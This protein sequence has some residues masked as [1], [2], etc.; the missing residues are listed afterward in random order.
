[1][2][3]PIAD[4]EVLTSL[5]T[6]IINTV[7]ASPTRLLQEHWFTKVRYVIE[8]PMNDPI[9]AVLLTR[10][11]FDRLS[12]DVQ[13][14]MKQTLAKHLK[15]FNGNVLEEN[16]EAMSVLYTD[17]GIQRIVFDEDGRRQFEF[18]GEEVRVQNL[19]RLWDEEILSA[20]MSALQ[21]YRLEQQN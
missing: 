5:Q 8:L 16:Q 9:G 3:V 12:P 19:G 13:I 11:S 20:A 14:L 21:A 6:G 1:M 17:H 18:L 2:P 7:Y 15:T 10:R 4:P